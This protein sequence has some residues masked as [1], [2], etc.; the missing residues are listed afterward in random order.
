MD[1]SW[2][3][4]DLI[5][6]YELLVL[7]ALVL[8]TSA[9]APQFV[10]AVA[11]GGGIAL[12]NIYGAKV[13]LPKA[14]STPG[15]IHAGYSV[16][17]LLKFVFAASLLALACLLFGVDPL[18]VAIGFGVSFFLGTGLALVH[19]SLS[20]QNTSFPTDAATSEPLTGPSGS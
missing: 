7:F 11:F 1:V 13:L 20:A 12:F 9:L 16:L 15:Q 5:V 14:L 4:I 2:R 3:M 10:N 19:T 6:R 8:G 18:G 17:M